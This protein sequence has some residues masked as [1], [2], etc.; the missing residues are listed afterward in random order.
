[1][2]PDDRSVT[3]CPRHGEPVDRCG[4][5]ES[6]VERAELAGSEGGDEDRG[7]LRFYERWLVRIGGWR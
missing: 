3:L 6:A 4:P 5:C 2:W 7:G 1:M